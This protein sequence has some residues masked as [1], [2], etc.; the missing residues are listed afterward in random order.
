MATTL[1]FIGSQTTLRFKES[2]DLVIPLEIVD[3]AGVA[4]DITGRVYTSE[5]VDEADAN[6]ATFTGAVT[7]APNG[8]AELTL[9]TTGVAPS[10]S[11]RWEVWEANGTD[12]TYL[13]GGPVVCLAKAF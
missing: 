5:I 6:V 8:L 10:S 11:Y 7:D 13:F 2:Q 1:D 9:D 3:G 12:D 4:I